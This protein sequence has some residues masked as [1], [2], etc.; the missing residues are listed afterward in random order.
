V[1]GGAVAVIQA[2]EEV[3]RPYG[4]LVMP[5]HSGDLSDPSGWQNPPV[6]ESWHETIRQ[7]MPAFDPDLTPT[8]GMGVIA[9]TFRKQTDVLRSIHPQVSFA[10]WGENAVNILSDHRLEYSMGDGSPL[11]R[12]YE[13]DG[14]VLFLGVGH[15]NNTSLHLAENR[16]EF[17]GKKTV[18][19]SS[20]V[21][22][23]GHRR[24]IRYDDLDYDN[25]DF[26]D[27]GKD[28]EDKYKQEVIAGKV[29]YGDARL[30]SQRLCVDYAVDWFTR[31]RRG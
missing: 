5:T 2:L 26:A 31:K 15:E 10:A 9:E 27:F 23:D 11:A 12:V 7:T 8:R 17:T 16:A 20:P 30:F 29:G 13:L 24:W 6:P 21:T 22:V 1:C 18:I 3:I 19:C 25:S 14:W 4:T 28:F